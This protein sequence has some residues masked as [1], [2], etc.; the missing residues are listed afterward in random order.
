M[1]E[2]Q[3]AL[4]VNR[5]LAGKLGNNQL[6]LLPLPTYSLGAENSWAS[7][8]EPVEPQFLPT[9]GQEPVII[10][11]PSVPIFEQALERLEVESQDT[12]M[13]GDRLSTD[14]LGGHRAGLK[15]LCV[16]TGISTREMAESYDPRPDW[17]VPD[18]RA[19]LDQ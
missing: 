9:T 15:T 18:L 4:P 3:F 17:I 19:V 13:V 10:G 16:L 12:I 11:K 14:I 7:L 8:I 5:R 1:N 2:I 6:W